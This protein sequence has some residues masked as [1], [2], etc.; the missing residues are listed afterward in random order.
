MEQKIKKER[1]PVKR[2]QKNVIK[3]LV[4]ENQRIHDYISPFGVKFWNS[5]L[6]ETKNID[7]KKR[8]KVRKENVA[9]A[10]NKVREY[11]E[12]CLE[13]ETDEIKI[14]ELKEKIFQ[15][16]IFKTDEWKTLFND[17]AR[18]NESKRYIIWWE[19]A[20]EEKKEYYINLHKQRQEQA[21]RRQES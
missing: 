19:R 7:T 20:P 6:R 11:F 16:S 13:T 5:I 8:K 4:K 17:E 12:R 15:L 1:K 14:Y 9:T 2:N 21:K 18:L 10:I 3:N